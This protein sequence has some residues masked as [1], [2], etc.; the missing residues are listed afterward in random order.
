MLSTLRAACLSLPFLLGAAPALSQEKDWV[1]AKGTVI[2]ADVI[3]AEISP[4][5]GWQRL[6]ISGLY[7]PWLSVRDNQEGWSVDDARYARVGAAG[8]RGADARALEP[9]AQYKYHSNVAFGA[10]LLRVPSKPGVV[11]SFNKDGVDYQL[12]AQEWVDF[13][14]NDTGQGD[15]GGVLSLCVEED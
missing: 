2:L 13:R 10:L 14:I 15:N 8:H 7:Q 9:Y 6:W 4:R 12:G 3:C 11:L 5:R 1:Q